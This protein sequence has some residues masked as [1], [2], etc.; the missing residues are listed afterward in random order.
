MGRRTRLPEQGNVPNR[1]RLLILAVQHPIDLGDDPI[2]EG[3]GIRGR[4]VVA[5]AVHDDVPD[6]ERQVVPGQMASVKSTK[7]E[8]G[9]R[10]GDDEDEDRG[11][12]QATGT[13]REES[14]PRDG[15]GLPSPRTR[16]PVMRKPERTKKTS[17]P[18]EATT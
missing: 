7:L 11:W 17:T 2:A 13:S 4:E 14:G 18:R 12:Q 1:L 16:R 3:R 6:H 9:T 10:R 15:A 8:V 5:G